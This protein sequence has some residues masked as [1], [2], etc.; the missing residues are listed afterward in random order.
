MFLQT[1]EEFTTGDTPMHV[2]GIQPTPKREGAA[3][4]EFALVLPV[5]CLVVFGMI[6]FGR[7]MMMSQVVQNA[8]RE[9]ARLASTDGATGQMVTEHINDYLEGALNVA[10]DDVTITI[11]IEAGPGNAEPSGVDDAS[12][13]DKCT[14]QVQVPYNEIALFKSSYFDNAKLRGYATMRREW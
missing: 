7:A 13:G 4:V 14:V 3:T 6:D 8:S 5:F 11:D 12:P 9:G 10:A 2:A 1:N